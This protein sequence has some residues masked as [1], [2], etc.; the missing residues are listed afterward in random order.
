MDEEAKARWFKHKKH[1]F[2]F[3]SAGK[4]VWARHGDE[5][6]L[7]TFMG[8]LTAIIG[9]FQ[10]YYSGVQ[11][12]LRCLRTSDMLV[13]FLCTEALWYVCISRTGESLFAL[14]KQ[15]E[16]IHLKI[17][18][19][20]TDNI[21]T[22]LMNR[23]N[24]DARNLMGG[25]D[26]AL[27]AIIKASAYSPSFLSA[28][29]P[30]KLPINIRSVMQ[31]SFRTNSS[32]DVLF[33][34]I[35]TQSSIVYQHVKRG[36]QQLEP[37]DILL[38]INL[39]S[40][41]TAL[42]TSMSWTPICLPGYSDKGFLYAY[43]SFFKGSRVG[44]TLISDNASGFKSLKTCGDGLEAELQPLVQ[45]VETAINDMPY[46]VQATGL[47][48]LRHF[49]YAPK[50]SGQFTMPGFFFDS[51]SK[52]CLPE[53]SYHRLLRR[54]YDCFLLST[55]GQNDRNYTRIDIYRN[56]QVLCIRQAEYTL[57]AALNP[58]LS[59]SAVVDQVAQLLKWLKQEEPS[60]LIKY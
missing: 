14:T 35:L 15:L 1:F 60:L 16:M 50:N 23:P 28:F 51:V 46:S 30:L 42:R 13:V 45:D 18:S 7:S 20:L 34:F 49:I 3:T 40:S 17:I 33:G 37:K 25:T 53:V 12:S 43:I 32:E 57:L 24:Y 26:V 8:T 4:P 39:L 27:E 10:N 54:Y 44:I 41:N 6:D 5:T 48:D 38:L 58:L 2:V 19:T 52:H 59:T 55:F 21:T 9:K 22:M 29:M 47:K 31:R 56:E 11:D 36:A